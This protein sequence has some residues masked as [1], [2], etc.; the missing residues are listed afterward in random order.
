MV[1][2]REQNHQGCIE[3]S[4]TLRCFLE[5]V[6]KLFKKVGCIELL[7]CLFTVGLKAIT[8]DL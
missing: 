8:L 1:V 3:L 7:R 2:L 4:K 6:V 5:A